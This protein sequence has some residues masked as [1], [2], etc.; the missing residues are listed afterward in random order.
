[1]QPEKNFQTIRVSL[2]NKEIRMIRYNF[3]R[4][5]KHTNS[6]ES[7]STSSVIKKKKKK[8]KK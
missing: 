1:M 7:S 6:E 8:K 5:K 2:I 4:I 3:R